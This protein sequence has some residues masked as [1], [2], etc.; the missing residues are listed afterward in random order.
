MDSA[1]QISLVKGISAI[2]GI[3]QEKLETF[4][5]KNPPLTILERPRMMDLTGTQLKK[6]EQLNSFLHASRMLQQEKEMHTGIDS[7][8]K[9]GKWFQSMIGFMKDKER[10]VMAYMDKHMNPLGVETM[11]IGTISE[12]PVYP[13]QFLRRAVE[14]GCNGVMISHNHPGGSLKPSG[15]DDDI[16][17]K[18]RDIFEPMGIRLHD[19]FIVT[20]RG[21]YSYQENGRLLSHQH[22]LDMSTAKPVNSNA[23]GSM[24]QYVESA[25]QLTGMTEFRLQ[26]IANA[27]ATAGV[28][29]LDVKLP[30][31]HRAKLELLNALKEAWAYAIEARPDNLRIDSSAVCGN[32]T[33]QS[34]GQLTQPTMMIYHLNTSNE[35]LTKTDIVRE[36]GMVD[37]KSIMKSVLESDCHSII[38]ARNTNHHMSQ[39]LPEDRILA[40]RM[41]DAL[42]PVG[43]SIVDYVVANQHAYTSMAEQGML[44]NKQ[45]ATADLSKIPLAA[46]ET[47]HEWHDDWEH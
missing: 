46:T 30:D 45:F 17:M 16:T 15:A 44:M 29:H 10:M 11:A 8:T 31:M 5:E 38:I 26:K 37:P 24:Q 19:H 33:V 21:Y 25:S 35:L 14:A 32:Y 18:L 1:H 7:T 3:S 41:V 6:I 47:S 12:A 2:T 39:V 27:E 40:K 43:V 4:L 34:L 13:R 28:T 20:D 9:A 23:T 36:K 22:G 42:N